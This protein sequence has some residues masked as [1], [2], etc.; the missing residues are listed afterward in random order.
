MVAVPELFWITD[1]VVGSTYT[2]KSG[3]TNELTMSVALSLC[4]AKPVLVPVTMIVNVPNIGVEVAE[5]FNVDWALPFAGGVTAVGSRVA[6]VPAGLPVTAS[7]TAWLKLLIEVTVT[8]N[9]V[10]LPG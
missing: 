1:N 2:A 10:E 3:S 7:C 6:D 8:V 4:V 5:T 9:I